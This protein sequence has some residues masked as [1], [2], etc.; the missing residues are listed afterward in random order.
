M[1]FLP[2]K[3]PTVILA[4][5]PSL[6]MLVLGSLRDFFMTGQM[7]SV[8]LKLPHFPCKRNLFKLKGGLFC[9]MYVF[10]YTFKIMFYMALLIFFFIYTPPYHYHPQ[11]TSPLIKKIFLIYPQPGPNT[12]THTHTLPLKR[13]GC[14]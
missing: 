3:I 9:S 4:D 11:H 7:F 6:F 2:H 10:N 14:R 8:S 12:H 5:S 13:A 1:L